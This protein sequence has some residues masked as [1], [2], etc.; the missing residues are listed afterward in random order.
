MTSARHEV[1][2]KR[3]WAVTTYATDDGVVGRGDFVEYSVDALQL[4]LALRRHAVVRLVVKLHRPA[5]HPAPHKVHNVLKDIASEKISMHSY[6]ST[7][8][9]TF[10]SDSLLSRLNSMSST[11]S[12]VSL[13]F[14]DA[15]RVFT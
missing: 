10:G 15:S 1:Q 14:T 2:E 4:L 3:E 8:S 5:L 12:Q 6:R 13:I 9:P 11:T 7:G